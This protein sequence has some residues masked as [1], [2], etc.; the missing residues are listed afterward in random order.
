[1]EN[2]TA[3]WP[4]ASQWPTGLNYASTKGSGRNHAC[5]PRRVNL[6]SNLEQNQNRETT[7]VMIR[8]VPNQYHRGHFMQ[9]LDRLGLCGK[10]DFV[11]LPID[12]Q[13]QWNVGYAFVNLESPEECDKCM[14]LMNGHKFKKLHPGQ[15]QRCAQV[16]VAHLQGIEANLAHFNNTAVFSSGSGLLQPWVRP[17]SMPRSHPQLSS[18]RPGHQQDGNCGDFFD[19]AQHDGMTQQFEADATCMNQHFF[20]FPANGAWQHCFSQ[21]Q[22]FGAMQQE[23]GQQVELQDGGSADMGKPQQ[24][25]GCSPNVGMPFTMMEANPSVFLAPDSTSPEVCCWPPGDAQ[26]DML[27]NAMPGVN[28][29]VMCVPAAEMA[30]AMEQG[31]I[32]MCSGPC[33][34]SPANIF[35][36]ADNTDLMS[37]AGSDFTTADFLVE[38]VAEDRAHGVDETKDDQSPDSEGQAE[39]A[40][41]CSDLEELKEAAPEFS[42]KGTVTPSTSSLDSSDSSQP[43]VLAIDGDEDPSC[44]L[45]ADWPALSVSKRKPTRR[46]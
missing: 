10:Y 3:S 36:H 32:P 16:S 24:A 45:G 28:Y 33:L 21:E 18:G 11:Y 12:R 38:E 19:T 23:D 1:M 7:T 44:R 30:C 42:Q 37:V 41:H 14:K 17:S 13:T 34:Y 26:L 9:E 15:Q 46:R 8:N 29:T 25:W 40:Q 22:C 20:A 39:L 27:Q 4:A 2:A 31:A 35:Q 43:E 5:V 6:A